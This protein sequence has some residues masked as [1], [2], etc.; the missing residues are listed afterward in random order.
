MADLDYTVGINTAIAE[1]N[2]ANLQKS[3]GGLND[4]FVRLKSTLATISLG[5][6]ITQAIKFAD[7][8]QDLADATDLSTAA[9]IGFGAAVAQNGGSVDGAQKGIA[10]LVAEIDDAANSAGASREAFKDVGVSLNDLRTKSTQDIFKQVIAGLAGIDDS[11]TKSRL[12]AILLNKEMKGVNFKGV[13]ADFGGN[14]ASAEKY[15]SATKAAAE[16]NDKLASAVA[17][18]QLKLVAALEPINKFIAG[19]DPKSI[20]VFADRLIKV[21]VALSGLFIIGK[22]ATMIESFIIMSRAA[23]ASTLSM[24]AAAGGAASIFPMFALGLKQIGQAFNI[25]TAATVASY[26][27]FSMLG[28][29]FKSLVTGFLRMIPFIGTAIVAFQLLDGV[30]EKIMGRSI[31]EYLQ[32]VAK[33]LGLI[34][35]TSGEA[36]KAAADHIANMKEIEAENEKARQAAVRGQEAIAKFQAEIA[37]ANLESKQNLEIQG[38]ALSNLGFRLSHERSLIGL[39]EDQKELSQQLYD[40][41]DQR[42]NKMSEYARAVKKL[43]QEQSLTKDEE[44]NKLLGARIGILKAEAKESDAQALRHKE[45]IKDQIVALQ[46]A[47]MVEKARLQDIENINKAIEDQISRQQQLGDVIRGI[48]DKRVDLRFGESLKGKSPLEK[49]IAQIKEDARKAALEAGRA[50]SAGFDSEEGLTA[51]KAKELSA[52]LDQIAQ[53]YKDITDA[54]ISALGVSTVLFQEFAD[55]QLT[56]IGKIQEE[57]KSGLIGAWDEYKNK[58][59][60]TAGQIKDS[61]G[62]FTQ[63]MEDAFVKFVQ[64]GKLSFADLANSV[65]ADL[66]RIAFKKAVIGMAGL[67]GFAAGGPVMAG[68]PIVVGERGPELFVPQSAG[69]IVPNNQL[70]GGGT[71]GEYGRGQTAV[72]YNIQAVDAQSFRSLV[73]RDPSFIYAVTEQGRRSQPTRSR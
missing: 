37:K 72:T 59:I 24:A 36:D 27:G 35:Q 30:F 33:G 66:A 65:I 60:D 63:G 20:E 40:L 17:T 1:R 38:Q 4:T 47:R 25:S 48:N 50:F 9:I 55:V 7:S 58:A 21:G 22:V 19:I 5:A 16:A 6:I 15:A 67:F 62:N 11:A 53:G 43:Q 42:F 26:T 45:G 71:G 10:K 12:A 69:K 2:L 52:G 73:A 57:I 28:I 18:F 44:Q 61:F 29:M 49:Q 14:T 64:T 13:G 41:D 31:Y 34:K 3:V 8:V 51:E 39:T 54:Q 56:A 32:E 70:G 46:S 68:T 23:S